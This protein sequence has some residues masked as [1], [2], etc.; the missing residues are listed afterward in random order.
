MLQRHAVQVLLA[1]GHT[2]AE[3]ALLTTVSERTER[4]IACEPPITGSA[5]VSAALT[6]SV[7]LPSKTAAFQE[8]VV[9]LLT[10]EPDLKTVEVLHRLRGRGYTGAKSAV[11]ELVATVRP[12]T[13]RLLVCFEGVPGDLSTVAPKFHSERRPNFHRAWG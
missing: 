12:M 1:A 4:R 6:Q 8:E 13:S 3:V 10:D 7:G 11:Y 5:A 2:H 9:K